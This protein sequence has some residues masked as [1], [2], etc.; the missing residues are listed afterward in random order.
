MEEC[1]LSCSLE[2]AWEW[3]LPLGILCRGKGW[4][5]RAG[6]TTPHGPCHRLEWRILH[7]ASAPDLRVAASLR[8]HFALELRSEVPA[9]AGPLY[10]VTR[11]SETRLGR[12]EEGRPYLITQI[13]PYVS[14]GSQVGFAGDSVIFFPLNQ[15]DFVL[16]N[17]AFSFLE[18]IKLTSSPFLRAGR[19]PV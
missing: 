7:L 18:E 3:E 19:K 5:R 2:Q 10:A 13:P 11:I 14:R 1:K 15:V 16:V 8:S 12:K 4:N 6:R 9:G 17:F